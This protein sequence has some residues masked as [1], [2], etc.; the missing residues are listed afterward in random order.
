[1][2]KYPNRDFSKQI[3]DSYENRMKQA[4]YELLSVFK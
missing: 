4:A 1:M 3:Y 2:E